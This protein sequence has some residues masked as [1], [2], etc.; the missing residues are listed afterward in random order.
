[1]TTLRTLYQK[2]DRASSR[3]W[4]CFLRLFP[5]GLLLFLLIIVMADGFH[6]MEYYRW[7]NSLWLLFSIGVIMRKQCQAQRLKQQLTVQAQTELLHQKTILDLELTLTQRQQVQEELVYKVFLFQTILDESPYV[8]GLYNEDSQILVCNRA[9]ELITGKNRQQIVGSNP[10]HLFDKEPAHREVETNQQILQTQ[11]PLSYDQWAPRML[12]HFEIHK[13][14]FYDKTKKQRRILVFGRDITERK[15]LQLALEQANR[16]KTHFIATISHELR[17][18]LSGIVGLSR[19]LR[20]EPLDQSLQQRYLKTI[21]HSALTLNHI[22]NDIISLEKFEKHQITLV[23]E[24]LSLP[25]LLEELEDLGQV[26]VE[27]KGLIFTLQSTEGLPELL[28]MDGTRLRQIIWNLLSN[29]VKFTTT[30][31]VKLRLYQDS[32]PTSLLVCEVTDSGI[33][34]SASEQ[35]KIFDMHYQVKEQPGLNNPTGTGIGLALSQHLAELMGGS[36]RVHSQLGQGTCFTLLLPLT[37]VAQPVIVP[38]SPQPVVPLHLLLIEDMDIT[39][40]ISTTIIEKLGHTVDV[41][42]SGAEALAHFS[43]NQY[44]FILLDI[45]LPDMSGFEVVKRLRATYPK[46]L[47]PPIVALTAAVL[48]DNNEYLAQGMDAVLNKPLST[49][50]LA[51]LIEHHGDS[52]LPNTLN[53]TGL[54][55]LPEAMLLL[56]DEGILNDYLKLLGPA[57]LTDNITLFNRILPTYLNELEQKLTTQQTPELYDVAHKI[58]NACATIGLKQLEQLAV[59]IQQANLPQEWPQVKQWIDQLHYQ[60][61][62]T[63]QFL[64]QWLA[65]TLY[66][67][68]LDPTL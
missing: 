33:G 51:A 3:C 44:H 37:P 45:Q 26:L 13:V 4:E 68:S 28:L 32:A 21:Y 18:P 59:K 30:G 34:I 56:L 39:I 36:L 41:V 5:I 57:G 54:E 8:I 58:Q 66:E 16:S 11:R 67:A 61:P 40:K 27:P 2:M 10:Y 14:F 49:E 24:P 12:A 29:A 20:E 60:W 47:L 17:T 62:Q 22:F 9:V 35:S 48:T 65:S 38:L 53:Q 25:A 52:A 31:S 46:A 19:L 15:T 6:P 50:S 64:N 23:S 1:M 7:I 43:P 42:M 55:M 63:L